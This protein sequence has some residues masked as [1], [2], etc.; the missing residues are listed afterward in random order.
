[1]SN[2]A[3]DSSSEDGIS[4]G[5]FRCLGS[6]PVY[7]SP[8]IQLREDRVLMPSGKEGTFGVITMKPGSSVVVLDVDGYTYLAREYKYGIER[9]S[10]E[11]VSGALLDGESPIDGAKRELEEE[12]GLI[13]VDWMDLGCVNPF[14]TIVNSPNYVFLAKNVRS[15]IQASDPDEK[16]VRVRIPFREAVEMVLRGD[17]THG[18][19]C[20]GILKAARIMGV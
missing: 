4:R 3:P 8:W 2:A 17:I 10:L 18:A 12:L 9:E 5:P 13:A 15:G 7:G 1:M 6:R 19:S 11:L 20:V 14:T 16:V